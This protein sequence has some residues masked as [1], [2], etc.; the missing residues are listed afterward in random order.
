MSERSEE[1]RSIDKVL[2]AAQQ[3]FQVDLNDRG[4]V[5]AKSLELNA[6][7]RKA[8]KSDHSKEERLADLLATYDRMSG[9]SQDLRKAA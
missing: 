2:A 4:A 6:A 1:F 3:D 8:G 7:A 5:M 9:K